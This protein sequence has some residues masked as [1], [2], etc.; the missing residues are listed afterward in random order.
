MQSVENDR[1]RA[2]SAKTERATGS[3]AGYL[4]QSEMIACVADSSARDFLVTFL[5]AAGLFIGTPL[6]LFLIAG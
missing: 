6:A 1:Q 4:L 3:I 5:V 2:H